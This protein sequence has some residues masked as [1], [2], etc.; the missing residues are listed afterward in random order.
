M[1]DMKNS[2]TKSKTSQKTTKLSSG[3][4]GYY[5]GIFAEIRTTRYLFFDKDT[6]TNQ[7]GVELVIN[8]PYKEA[9]EAFKNAY[10]LGYPEEKVV[11][12]VD[13][14]DF[15]KNFVYSETASLIYAK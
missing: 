2:T 7:R 8:M 13:I 12:F 5:K 14:L 10:T 15:R 9:R 4:I 6:K 1:N 3:K 11:V